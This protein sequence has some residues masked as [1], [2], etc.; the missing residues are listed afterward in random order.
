M[1]KGLTRCKIVLCTDSGKRRM[2]N[3]LR[4]DFFALLSLNFILTSF[5]KAF[6]QKA[7]HQIK[8]I[9]WFFGLKA[10]KDDSYQQKKNTFSLRKYIKTIFCYFWKIWSQLNDFYHPFHTF[11]IKRGYLDLNQSS[12]LET[13]TFL[14]LIFIRNGSVRTFDQYINHYL[15]GL[16]LNV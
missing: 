1:R 2:Q 8:S 14:G 4:C 6:Q 3:L 12:N 16:S 5:V 15:V 9:L 10:C 7:L 11:A 13:C